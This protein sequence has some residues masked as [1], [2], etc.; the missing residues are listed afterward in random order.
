[1]RR[2]FLL[3]GCAGLAALWNLHPLT[4]F[5]DI[6]ILL[7]GSL[8]IFALLVWGWPALLVGAAAGLATV[9]LWGH[10]AS[11][12]T[13]LLQ[14][15]WLQLF[16]SRFNGRTGRR[17]N[18]RV[19]LASLAYWL[20]VGGPLE[21]GWFRVGMGVTATFAAGIALKEIVNGVLCA[22]LGLG[23]YLAL[24]FWNGRHR[25]GTVSIRGL[26][27]ALVL[28]AILLPALVVTQLQSNQLRL[29]ALQCEKES[30]Q[31]LGRLA[32]LVPPEQLNA[33]LAHSRSPGSAVQIHLNPET[34][35]SS[36]P[37]LFAR[38]ASGYRPEQGTR[39]PLQDLQLLM[40]I[41]QQSVLHDTLDGY[42]RVWLPGPPVV[43]VVR[44]AAPLVE[45]MDAHELLG[46]FGSLVVL[47]LLGALISDGLA[48]ALER[49][50]LVL[51]GPSQDLPS[52]S[53]GDQVALP[54][55]GSPGLGGSPLRELDALAT[56]I[57]ARNR[58]LRQGR[59]QLLRALD[60]LP[61]PVVCQRLDH[62]LASADACAWD[63]PVILLNRQFQATFGYTTDQITSMQAWADL[64]YPDGAARERWLCRWRQAVAAARDQEG[65]IRSLEETVVCSNGRCADVRIDAVASGNLLIV[66]LLDLTEHNRAERHLRAMVER[67][68]RQDEWQRQQLQQRLRSSLSAAA[69]VHEIKQ[70]LSTILLN[71][72]LALQTL[73]RHEHAAGP[74]PQLRQTLTELT[75]QA[76]R[77]V[78]IMERM[79]ML[80]RNVET[81]H[82]TVDLAATVDS[83]LLFLKRELRQGRVQLCTAGLDQPCMVLGDSAQLQ[84]AITNVIRNA[85]EAMAQP[86]Q[87]PAVRRRLDVSLVRDAQAVTVVVADCGPG[88]SADPI[89]LPLSSSKPE[90]TD[91][92]LFVVRTTLDHHQGSLSIG[93]S[94][95]LGGAEVR[96]RLP[97]SASG[98]EADSCNVAAGKTGSAT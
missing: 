78:E 57:N 72:R 52:A 55:L 58:A 48:D 96:L 35:I 11:L 46:S 15:V 59:D 63:G 5:F 29:L 62:A 21:Y 94:E 64:V 93:R 86:D 83:S 76:D 53:P 77:V 88:C 45:R 40:A 65:K 44:P 37:A 95:A 87:P 24:G 98:G 80:L 39:L 6:Q 85:I 17:D 82:T 30:L 32:V 79:R 22:V 70:P 8:A 66:S 56:A 89:D 54:P 19:V 7:G 73:D 60:N 25:R 69:V 61:I 47:M 23:F 3:A 26:A 51:L 33:V 97:L 92:G 18:G 10:P 9:Q 41:D 74:P 16:L 43:E 81:Q 42:W 71:C 1:M 14:L 2:A 91:I 4:F 27:F 36:D 13:G 49:Q 12:L 75:V 67:E 20:L 68:K 84:I 38:L 90:G 34:V 28:S 31:D 50:F